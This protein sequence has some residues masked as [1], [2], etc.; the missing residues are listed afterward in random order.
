MFIETL[1]PL[2][3]APDQESPRAPER[4]AADLQ[5]RPMS[6]AK[7]AENGTQREA[8]ATDEVPHTNVPAQNAESGKIPTFLRF[9]HEERARNDES[10]AADHLRYPVGAIDLSSGM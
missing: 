2:N 6:I 1:V 8:D 3:N 10:H 5:L 9:D 7:Q 4:R